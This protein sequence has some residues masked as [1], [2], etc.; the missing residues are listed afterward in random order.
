MY[1]DILFDSG[2]SSVR[3]SRPQIAKRGCC[4]ITQLRIVTRL[5]TF[6]C[7]CIAYFAY[8]GCIGFVTGLEYFHSFFHFQMGVNMVGLASK[9]RL[10][11]QP[12]DLFGAE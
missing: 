1:T 3:S 7:I 8:D 2:Q 5:G 10:V 9:S 4:T 11:D 6:T 12:E